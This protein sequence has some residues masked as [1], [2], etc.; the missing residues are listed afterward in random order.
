MIVTCEQFREGM[1]EYAKGKMG[2]GMK[3]QFDDHLKSCESCRRELDNSASV[4]ALID[5]GYDENVMKSVYQFIED[6]INDG[7]SDIHFEPQRDKMRVRFRIDG[8]LHE[9]ATIKQEMMLPVAARIKRMADMNLAETRIPQDGRIPIRYKELAL[10][11]RVSSQPTRY[12][13]AFVMRILSKSGFPLGLDQL[14]LYPDQQSELKKLMHHPN[15]LI[16][17]TAPTGAGST[18]LAYSMLMQVDAAHCKV[19]TVEDP[20]ELEF[21][22][23][24]QVQVHKQV[25][26]TFSCAARSFMRS[27]PDVILIGETYDL[28]TARTCAAAASTGHLILTILHT[29][30]SFDVL[31]LL[32]DMGLEPYALGS[33]LISIISTRLVRKVCPECKVEYTPKPEALQVIGIDPEQAQSLKFVKGDGCEKCKHIG[34]RGRTG[35]FEVVTIDRE[36][37]RM[38]SSGET[39]ERIR[40]EAVD[41]GLITI[42]AD[43][44]RKVLNGITTAEEAARVLDPVAVIDR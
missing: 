38:I 26:L 9:Y 30:I 6:A 37:A 7:A 11:V 12:G 21:S 32:T 35:I 10:D 4:I 42:E 34:Y 20:I 36:L 15:G 16:V 44:R 40:A 19:L 39:T 23:W 18:T 24:T 25:G 31:Q 41:K 17:I 27:D 14:G 3:K 13:E 8:V 1:Y 29:R 33:S 43:A 22:D 5:A 2:K 28:E